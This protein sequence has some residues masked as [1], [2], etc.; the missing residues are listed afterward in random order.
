MINKVWRRFQ[1]HYNL[2]VIHFKWNRICSELKKSD[3]QHNSP[4][5]KKV[6]IIPADFGT[7]YGSIGDAAMIRATIDQIHLKVGKVDIHLLCRESAV[8]FIQDSEVEPVLSK[9]DSLRLFPRQI[10]E[11]YKRQKYTHVVALGADVMDGYYRIFHPVCTV[12]AADIAAK[13][14]KKV[15][16]L[17]GS[18][19]SQ[20]RRELKRFF[21]KMDP[22]VSFNLRDPVSFNRFNQFC[23]INSNLVAD[24]AFSLTPQEPPKEAENWLIQQKKKG[25][26]IIGLNL[27]PMLIKNINQAQLNDLISNFL[28]SLDK[29]LVGRDMFSFILIPHDYRSD[30]GDSRCLKPVFDYLRQSSSV[31]SFYLIGKHKPSSLKAL[32]G[33]LDGLISGRMHLAIAALGMGVPVMSLTYQDK[34]DG[35]YQHFDLPNALML[36][37]DKLQDIDYSGRQ[38]SLFFDCLN[39]T[40]KAVDD[41]KDKVLTLSKKNFLQL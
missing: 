13:M 23:S 40:R 21:Q 28:Q 7:V 9:L 19:N 1:A 31:E 20:P 17:G 4:D 3:K 8:D 34:F 25:K 14:G 26:K 36:S 33:M 2:E 6:L 41:A 24:V 29:S 32:S 10:Y 35:L 16:V 39:E 18:F 30:D 37:A 27:H 15:I 11:L 22:R 12:I 5:R 38:F